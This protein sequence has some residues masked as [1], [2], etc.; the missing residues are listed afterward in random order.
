MSRYSWQDKYGRTCVVGWDNPLQSY[1]WQIFEEGDEV[2]GSNLGMPG[3]E[4][5]NTDDLRAYA[6]FMIGDQLIDLLETD[7]ANAG[8]PSALQTAMKALMKGPNG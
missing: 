7:K 6:R 2:G 1:F 5:T 3:C 4:I 8:S